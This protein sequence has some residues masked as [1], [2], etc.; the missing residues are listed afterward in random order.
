[1]S[2]LFGAATSDRCEINNTS[3]NLDDLTAVTILMWVYPTAATSNRFWFRKDN[4]P[5]A[6]NRKSA[7]F[8]AGGNLNRVEFVVTRATTNASA[9]SATNSVS[10]NLWQF[11]AFTYDETDGPRIFRGTLTSRVVELGYSAG[12]T[13]GA[14]AT[15][16]DG[17]TLWIGNQQAASPSLAFTGRIAAFSYIAK[18]M[19][20]LEL[21]TQ[22]F[23]FMSAFGD[24]RVLMQ[25]GYNGT[26][27][28]PDWSGN[29][30][31]GTVTGATV[32]PHVPVKIWSGHHIYSPYVVLPSERHQTRHFMQSWGRH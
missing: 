3:A 6:T 24:S 1:M 10:T 19:T 32:A 13:V 9:T 2:L 4:N 5:A 12:P 21:A 30:N 17:S 27:T 25:L 11:F 16:T 14:G 31:S 22:Q 28:Q 7:R 15:T 18:R 29:F 23:C 8:P 26:G 20:L